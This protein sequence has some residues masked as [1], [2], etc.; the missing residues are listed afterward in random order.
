MQLP[1]VHIPIH[2][3]RP[4]AVYQF[5]AL[6]RQADGPDYHVPTPGMHFISVTDGKCP[7]SIKLDFI[8]PVS[9]W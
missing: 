6:G 5:E 8:Y 3:Q 2:E 1:S 9:L 4:L 7:V